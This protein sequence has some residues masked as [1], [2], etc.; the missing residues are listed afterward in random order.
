MERLRALHPTL[1]AIRAGISACSIPDAAIRERIRTDARRYGR[2]WCPHTATAA[3]AWSRLPPERRAGRHWVL[4]ATAHPAKFREIVEPLI[5][6]PVPVPEALAKLFDRP[7]KY[8]ELDA[9]LE[10]L[11]VALGRRGA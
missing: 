11:R 3:E 5:G 4:V 2:I 8:A 10:A 1:E 6:K 9:G 7:V